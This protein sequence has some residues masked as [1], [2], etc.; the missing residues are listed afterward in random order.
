MNLLSRGL[1]ETGIS[2]DKT[3]MDRLGLYLSELDLW[4]KKGLVN[5]EGDDL[6]VRHFLDCIAAFPHFPNL[7]NKRIA[8]LGSGAGF[9]GI[10]IALFFPDTRIDLVE[11]QAGR[12]AFLVN[13]VSLLGLGDRVKVIES[14]VTDLKSGYD[15]LVFRAFRPFEAMKAFFTDCLAS[16]T[17]LIAYKGRNEN[18]R[19]D[20]ALFAPFQADLV[21][22]NVPFLDEERNLL[23]LYG[24]RGPA[25][26]A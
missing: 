1:A 13:C 26:Q 23:V 8:D 4:K 12:A 10:L 24:P 18:A 6:I 21:K 11:R 15:Y 17:G 14:D 7:T 3:T 5:A 22:I 25:G 2:A 20:R 19:Q 9:P 16:G